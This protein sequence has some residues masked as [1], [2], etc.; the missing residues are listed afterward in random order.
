MLWWFLYLNIAFRGGSAMFSVTGSNSLYL[1]TFR[2]FS[3][4]E[5]K[6]FRVSAVSDLVFQISPISLIL[7][8]SLMRD[9]SERK[10]FTDFQ[11]SLFPN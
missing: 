9:L 7:I 11:N 10:G 3:I 5:K 4:F 8:L 6:L 1:K 2:F